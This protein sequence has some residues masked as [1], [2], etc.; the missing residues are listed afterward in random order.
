MSTARLDVQQYTL[1]CCFE[2][3]VE[4]LSTQF[5]TLQYQE[6][7]ENMI[8]ITAVKAAV[9]QNDVN[10]SFRIV[11]S[12]NATVENHRARGETSGKCLHV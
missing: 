8:K 9:N 2:T 10:T 5:L 12:I 11:V 3:C 6:R 7:G 1:K 4:R